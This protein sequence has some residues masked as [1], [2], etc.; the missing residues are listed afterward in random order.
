MSGWSE[1]RYKHQQYQHYQYYLHTL[2]VLL[3]SITRI[4]SITNNT[5]ISYQHY[6]QY[7]HY[8]QYRHYTS[9]TSIT[10]VTRIISNTN[11]TSSGAFPP[12][13]LITIRT[14]AHKKNN[15]W[16]ARDGSSTTSQR[17]CCGAMVFAAELAASRPA[18]TFARSAS[19]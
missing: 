17:T 9:I 18:F 7:Q 4:T 1:R 14:C 3:Y 8:Q 19:I 13:P 16:L 10:C 15:G 12:Q 5:S 6:H 2:P 11:I